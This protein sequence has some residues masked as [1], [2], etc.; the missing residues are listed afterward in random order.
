M[1]DVFVIC[2]S[3]GNDGS[4]KGE[5]TDIISLIVMEM[6]NYIFHGWFTSL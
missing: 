4:D 1:F 2:D 6:D 3:C 5:Q